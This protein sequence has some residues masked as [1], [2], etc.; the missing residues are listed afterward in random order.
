[1]SNLLL[2]RAL[3]FVSGSGGGGAENLATPDPK[4]IWTGSGTATLSLGGSRSVDS[5]FVGFM[6]GGSASVS[7]FGSVSAAPSSR[8][9]PLRQHGFKRLSSP[10]NVGS[11]SIT[12]SGAVGIIAVGLAF[13]PTFN[14]EWGAGRVPI[15]S[16]AREP[17]LGG[18]FGIGAGARKSGYR[19]T[20]GDIL[21]SEIERLY[22]IAESCGET[23][24]VVVVEDPDNTEGLNERLHYGLFERFE[25]YE[26][27]NPSQTRWNLQISQWV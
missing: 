22:E 4:E 2:F 18:G 14:K 16:G 17:L 27:A 24:P 23:G 19:W 26:R 6:E 25:P 10:I 20:F 9:E 11:L 21:N 1:M 5:V 13:Q 12:S 8:S 7:G 3:P 15:D